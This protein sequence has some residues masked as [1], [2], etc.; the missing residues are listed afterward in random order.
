MEE[1]E[2]DMIRLVKEKNLLSSVHPDPESQHR[3]GV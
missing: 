1:K 2:N 3:S